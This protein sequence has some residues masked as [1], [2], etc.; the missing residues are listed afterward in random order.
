[1]EP[2][3]P[4]GTHDRRDA[5]LYCHSAAIKDD[6]GASRVLCSTKRLVK[7]PGSATGNAPFIWAIKGGRSAKR[8]VSTAANDDT[9]YLVGAVPLRCLPWP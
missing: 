1:M 7:D 5:I 8:T 4:F 6:S 3:R 2:D 9:W